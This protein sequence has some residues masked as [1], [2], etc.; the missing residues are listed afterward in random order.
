M[1]MTKQQQ[2][3][4]KRAAPTIKR[5]IKGDKRKIRLAP[6]PEKPKIPKKGGGMIY[7]DMGGLVGG[8]TKLDMNKDGMIT[9]QDFKMMPKKYGGKITYRMSGGKV[10]SAGYDD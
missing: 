5:I 9:G 4:V 2:D 10:A 1:S 3:A 6:K 7:K 8:Q